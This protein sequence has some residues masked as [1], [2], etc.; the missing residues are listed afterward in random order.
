VTAAYPIFNAKAVN[1][2]RIVHLELRSLA[3]IKL[4]LLASFPLIF[5]VQGLMVVLQMNQNLQLISFDTLVNW[6][7]QGYLL[8][9]FSFFQLL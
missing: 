7:L 5:K 6:K 3:I 8:V 4:G 1:K 2:K 9:K